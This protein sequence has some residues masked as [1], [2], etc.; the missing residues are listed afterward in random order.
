MDE[1]GSEQARREDV[2]FVM[3]NSRPYDDTVL[4]GVAC[5]TEDKTWEVPQR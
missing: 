2:G 4:A 1:E 5:G 3:E